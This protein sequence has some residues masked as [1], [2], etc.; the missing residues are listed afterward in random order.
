MEQQKMI[1]SINNKWLA[2][3]VVLVAGLGLR[4]GYILIPLIE[5]TQT[6]SVLVS[7][8]NT[9]AN[10]STTPIVNI[11]NQNITN[12][13]P[14]A[15][16]KISPAEAQKIASTYIQVSGATAGTPKLV[17]QNSKLIYIVPVIDN[18]KNVGEIDIDA[19]NGHN[20]GGTP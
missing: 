16:T 4:V 11:T 7:T 6:A 2:L 20:L 13:T 18:G 1:P 19:Q 5:P 14:S 15:Q 8:N 12:N 17:N 3:I 10:N 9:T